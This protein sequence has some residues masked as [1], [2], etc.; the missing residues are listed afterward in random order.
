MDDQITA[1]TVREW[2]DDDLV[3]TVEKYP[4][5]AAEFNFTIEISNLLVHV[6]R[7]Q[8]GGPILIG[9]EVEYGAEIRSDIQNLSESSRNE[10]VAR[11]RETLNASPVIY[12][13]HDEQGTNV[14]FEE[15]QRIFVEQR[16]YSDAL[17]QHALMMG[18]IDTWKVLRYVDDIVTL[19]DAVK[20]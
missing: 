2:I 7:R 13:F 18:L 11:V 12:G 14:R 5:E 1:D 15:L 16:I 4:D 10:L 3:D 17:G 20:E 19:I 9:Q 6:L 8:P